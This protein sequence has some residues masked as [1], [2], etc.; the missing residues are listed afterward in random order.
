MISRKKFE[1]FLKL[2]NEKPFRIK[3]ILTSYYKNSIKDFSEVSDLP[4]NLRGKLT[5]F[6]LE[7]EKN[8]PE[9]FENV[10]SSDG[11]E[12]VLFKTSDGK[13]FESV[14][15]SHENRNT[16]CVSSQIGC[17]VKCAFCMTGAMGFFRNL[18][19]FEILYQVKFW[20][21]K[22]KF[23]NIVFMGQG[24]PFL[25]FDAVIESIET[26]SDN[27]AF[28]F[29]A[30]H[31]TVSTSGITNKILEFSNSLRG[32]GN[33]AIS[34]H[35]P[36]QTLRETLVPFAKKFPLDELMEV[37]NEYA[38]KT[39]RK[40]F[41]EYVMLKNVNDSEKEAKECG[42]ILS[43]NPLFHLNLINYN[44]TELGFQK[45]TKS[46]I[47]NFAKIVRSFGVQVT[48]RPSHGEESFSAC[49]QLGNKKL[50]K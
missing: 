15:I 13:F 26:L 2:E 30:R 11:T 6:V 20:Q 37:S 46:R 23:Q 40:V 25:N 3:Q 47:E 28:G 31:I 45:S 8:L 17:P 41:F 50:S 44:E 16:I 22:Y 32:Q 29:G 38:K 39:K 12:K 35:A 33:L 5:N 14:F 4:K 24:E 7:E 27:M 42:K 49:G 36:N 10:S 21:E 18:T 43:K 48:I 9:E 19:S 1:N 34:L